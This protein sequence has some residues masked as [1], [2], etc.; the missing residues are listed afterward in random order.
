[1]VGLAV[2]REGDWMII[3]GQYIMPVAFKNVLHSSLT[4]QY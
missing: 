2:G 4:L 3:M 1:M